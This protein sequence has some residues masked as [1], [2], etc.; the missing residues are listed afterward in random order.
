MKN[1]KIL[2]CL[3]IVFVSLSLC[4]CGITNGKAKKAAR[5]YIGNKYNQD[6]KIVDVKK[7]YKFTGQ[8][9]GLPP[10]GIESDESYNLVM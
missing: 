1:K 9:G 2:I 6:A 8:G 10:T 5:E 7:N 3:M 4:G